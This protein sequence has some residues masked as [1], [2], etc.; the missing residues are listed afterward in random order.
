MR[1]LRAMRKIALCLS[2]AVV[3]LASCAY[4]AAPEKKVLRVGMDGSTSG[5]T[6]LNDKGELEGF[7]VDVWKEIAK[8]NDCEVKFEQMPFSSLLGMV[9]DGRVDTVTNTLAPT[10]ERKEVYNFS[11]PYLYDEQNLMSSPSIQARTFKDLDGLRIGLVPGSVDEAFIN[12]IEKEYSIKVKRVYFDDTAM[13]DVVMGKIDACVQSQTIALEAIRRFGADKIKVLI[14]SGTYFESAYPFAKTPEG[15]ALR[16]M[17][18]R[19]LEA[20]KKDGTLRAISEKWF[21]F[22]F[23]VKH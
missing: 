15:D 18:N 5:F 22:D 4:G 13:Q 14:G 21:N 9:S 11:E 3:L 20:M 6:V 10:E 7:E 23:T 12:S 16:E 1:G 8:R 2:V 19:T 17:T